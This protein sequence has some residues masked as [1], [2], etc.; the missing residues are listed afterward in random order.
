MNKTLWIIESTRDEKFP[1]RLS[2]KNGDEN[3]LCLRVQDRWPGTKG[4]IFCMRE[5]SRQWQDI[6]EEVERVPVLSLRRYG[7]RLVVVLDRA[8]NKRCDFLF[9]EKQYKTKEGSY[10]QIFWRTQRS[11][12]ER[13]PK[14]K[15]TT[16][17]TYDLYIIIDSNERYPLK[18]SGCLTEKG[19]LPVG[20]YALK[21]GDKL[22]AVVERKTYENIIS[23]FGRMSAF[24]QQLTELEV[25]EHNALIIEANYSDFLN[26]EKLKFYKP[27]FAAKAIAEIFAFHPKLNIVFAGNR[28]LANEWALRFF[29]AIK[30]HE[31]DSP[32]SK[33]AEV[34]ETYGEPPSLKGGS[35][36]EVREQ[37]EQ[38]PEKFTISMLREVCQDI[39]EFTIRKA[40]SEMKRENKIRFNKNV[41]E[42]IDYV[43]RKILNQ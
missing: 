27:A 40:L 12:R 5:E 8:K 16:Y 15:L 30:A 34:L 23:E 36:F 25:Y 18:F 7:R 35:Y 13:K 6:I 33:I 14:V 39:P 11:L 28:K 31:Q 3:I 21:V 2:I 4:Q 37:I 1:L 29:S 42:K 17:R 24:H 19:R 22:L 20:D 9:L 43:S 32:P 10:E 26:P 38:M 41:W